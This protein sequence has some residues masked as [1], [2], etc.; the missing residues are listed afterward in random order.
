MKGSEER[1]LQFSYDRCKLTPAVRDVATSSADFER[2]FQLFR[3][4]NA[5]PQHS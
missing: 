5:G 3:S 2:S 4:L 1:E